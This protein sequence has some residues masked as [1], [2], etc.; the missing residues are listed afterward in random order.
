M[1]QQ[2]SLDAQM[3]TV[4]SSF[5]DFTQFPESVV[6]VISLYS[7]K[8]A[9]INRQYPNS[10]ASQSQPK[11]LATTTVPTDTDDSIPFTGRPS[12]PSFQS[13]QRSSA[14]EVYRKPTPRESISP[15]DSLATKGIGDRASNATEQLRSSLYK[16]DNKN[17]NDV[18]RH[19]KEQNMLLITICGDLSEELLSVQQK[20]EEIKSKM[21]SEGSQT[22]MIS[23]GL[24]NNSKEV[25]NQST[26]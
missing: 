6:E 4:N 16:N 12:I 1:V 9:V 11:S 2:I 22:G 19:L 18:M 21:D 23:I 20:K 8:K 25:A 26:V 10:Q 5:A 17:L 3:E 24:L 13:S 15:P 14:F 7:F